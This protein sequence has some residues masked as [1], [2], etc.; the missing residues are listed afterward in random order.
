MSGALHQS[1]RVV[2]PVLGRSLRPV[3]GR[4][5]PH[6]RGGAAVPRLRR[7]PDACRSA[8]CG[9]CEVGMTK[10]RLRWRKTPAQQA[11]MQIG[12]TWFFD[13]RNEDP[14]V[15]GWIDDDWTVFITSPWAMVLSFVYDAGRHLIMWAQRELMRHTMALSR[16]EV[17]RGSSTAFVR[18]PA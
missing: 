3:A 6:A 5:W 8:D 1:H 9:D 11:L 10:R 13:H 18:R 16:R 7:R 14:W 2:Y 15:I 4:P 17:P 12:S